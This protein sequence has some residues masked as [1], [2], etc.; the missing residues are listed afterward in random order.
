MTISTPL[1]G[2][3]ATLRTRKKRGQAAC[4]AMSEIVQLGRKPGVRDEEGKL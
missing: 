4:P 3:Y 1:S 2:R